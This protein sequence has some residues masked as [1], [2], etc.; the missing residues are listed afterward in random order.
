MRAAWAALIPSSER[1]VAWTSKIARRLP[2]QTGPKVG[3][4]AACLKSGYGEGMTVEAIKEE[5]GNLSETERK[6]LL[7]WLEDLEEEVWDREIERDF[8]PGGRAERLMAEVEADIAAGRTRPLGEV[9]VEA[10]TRQNQSR[11]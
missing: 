6:Q 2:R 8:A 1:A 5:I 4:F 9:L 3:G 10:K 11:Q 7:D